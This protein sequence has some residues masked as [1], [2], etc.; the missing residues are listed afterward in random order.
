ML[1]VVLNKFDV[2][3][4]Y[5]GYYGSYRYGYYGYGYGYYNSNGKGEHKKRS[6]KVKS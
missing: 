2:K 4:A 1:G 5:G 3:K 6:R